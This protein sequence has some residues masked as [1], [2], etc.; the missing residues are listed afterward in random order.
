MGPLKS[1]G[2]KLV[3]DAS[4]MSELLADAFS[5][6]LVERALPFLL[7][8]RTLLVCWMRFVSPGSVARAL[9][10]LNSS[11]ADG[12]EVLHPHLLKACSAAL[13]LPFAFYL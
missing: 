11:S 6:V 12:P 10:G 1:E 4:D 5:P 8:I 7:S 9:S 3:S 13:S 2:G